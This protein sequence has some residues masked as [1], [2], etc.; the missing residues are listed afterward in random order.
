MAGS[1]FIPGHVSDIAQRFPTATVLRAVVYFI[2]VLL[3]RCTVLLLYCCTV[4]QFYCTV[5]LLY[6]LYSCTV[7]LY[8][9]IAVLSVLSMG[10]RRQVV[11]VKLPACYPF[12]R[13]N[14]VQSFI[15]SLL[16]L[17]VCLQLKTS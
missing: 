8:S 10:T 6:C 11:S 1:L 9:F 14:K 13:S 15:Q 2:A 12:V 5:L 16:S 3:Y 4:V 7:L 17:C